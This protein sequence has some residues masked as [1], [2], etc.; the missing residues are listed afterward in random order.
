MTVNWLQKRI[1][2]I[3]WTSGD[4]ELIRRQL[5][6]IYDLTVLKPQ[7]N[8]DRSIDWLDKN[9]GIKFGVLQDDVPRDQKELDALNKPIRH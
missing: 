6:E 4:V 5:K 9:A 1:G 8:L 7:R 2:E 3:S